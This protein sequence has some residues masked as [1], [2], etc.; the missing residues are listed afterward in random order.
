MDE[1]DKGAA[2]ERLIALLKA[3]YQIDQPASL[4]LGDS[5]WLEHPAGRRAAYAT[6]SLSGDGFLVSLLPV[7]DRTQLRIA[8]EKAA[9]FWRFISS[10]PQPTWWERHRRGFYEVAGK[11]AFYVFVLVLYLIF[12]AISSWLGWGDR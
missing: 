10:V 5:L 8:P 7:G 3:G 2:I 9:D 6:L 11:L 12:K 1:R 4:E